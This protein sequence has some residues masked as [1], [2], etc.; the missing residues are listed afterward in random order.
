MCIFSLFFIVMQTSVRM[1][2]WF[3]LEILQNGFYAFL[4]YVLGPA[5]L[6]H[7][8]HQQQDYSQRE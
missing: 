4:C 3:S 5:S 8:A 6:K 2:R 1:S 7:A